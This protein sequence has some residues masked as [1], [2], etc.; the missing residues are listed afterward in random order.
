MRYHIDFK[1]NV[2]RKWRLK[3]TGL[4][5]LRF[6]PLNLCDFSGQPVR[7]GGFSFFPPCSPWQRMRVKILWP[8]GLPPE[9]GS[10]ADV[11]L[12]RNRRKMWQLLKVRAMGDVDGPEAAKMNQHHRHQTSVQYLHLFLAG[13]GPLSLTLFRLFPG[14]GPG[15][16][17]VPVMSK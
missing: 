1:G 4:L 9:D 11:A 10:T 6:L 7:P 16:G 8:K 3:H 13:S 2:P 12:K 5:V 17:P 15:P 14:P